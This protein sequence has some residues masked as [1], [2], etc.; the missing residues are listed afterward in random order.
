MSSRPFYVQRIMGQVYPG[1]GQNNMLEVMSDFPS[2]INSLSLIS[3]Q[4]LAAEENYSDIGC[5]EKKT[6]IS[7]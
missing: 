2:V 7:K 1:E 6:G 5:S 3:R 4:K